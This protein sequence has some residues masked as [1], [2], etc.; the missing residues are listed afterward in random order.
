MGQYIE[1]PVFE[2]GAGISTVQIS[3][4]RPVTESV[5]PSRALWVPF[6]FG[7]PLGPP[8]SPDIQMDVL[9]ATLGLVDERNGPAVIDYLDGFEYEPVEDTAWSC[10]VTFPAAVPATEVGTLIAQIKQE[11]QL[12]RPWFD[13]GLRRRGRTAV[14]TSGKDADS[15]DEMLEILARFAANAE[16]E[17]PN[18]YAHQMPQL[19]RYIADDVRAF[20][21][22]AAT[23]K[24]GAAFPLPDDLLE[25]FFLTTIA[26]ET[27]YRVR[28]KLL[29][30]DILVLMAGGLDNDIIDDRLSLL[31]GTTAS[32]EENL[33]RQPGVSRELFQWSAEVFQVAQPN[34]L[35]WTIVPV[36]MRDRRGERVNTEIH[37][38]VLPK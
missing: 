22:E 37:K 3:L 34:R 36:A 28:E 29:A 20:Y 14:G 8:N 16:L 13:E 31:P 21:N 23:S 9:R 30:A 32:Q 26:G 15:I 27:F 19:L 24:P 4:V 2:G 17:V 11:V 6:P 12:L 35:S 25:W 7:R 5:K 33:L 10:P 38:K 18:G 1:R